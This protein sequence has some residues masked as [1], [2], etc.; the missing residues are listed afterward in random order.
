MEAVSMYD[1]FVQGAKTAP[2]G[3]RPFANTY[4]SVNRV[5][6]L[7][8]LQCPSDP[9][10]KVPSQGTWGWGNSK[11]NVLICRGDSTWHNARRD[12]QETGIPHGNS[13]RGVF[14]REVWRGFEYCVDGT[15]NTIAAGEGVSPSTGL[16]NS[17]EVKGGIYESTTIHD[18]RA[19]PKRCLDNAY[20]S[21][22]TLLNS[23]CDS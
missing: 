16:N 22:R 7:S 2:S 8:T 23:G 20:S 6:S 1:I 3:S 21:D 19:F 9:Y 14:A 10:V 12:D 17:T 4:L 5:Q 11:V 15:S 13:T 18:G